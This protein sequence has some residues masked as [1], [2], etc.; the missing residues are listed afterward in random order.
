MLNPKPIPDSILNTKYYSNARVFRDQA[1]N[2]GFDDESNWS[3][4]PRHG[5]YKVNYFSFFFL[6]YKSVKD[7][8]YLQLDLAV[9]WDIVKDE[10][11]GDVVPSAIGGEIWYGMNSGAKFSLDRPGNYLE[12]AI[13]TGL[14]TLKTLHL[15]NRIQYD[16][17]SKLYTVNAL[18]LDEET[19]AVVDEEQ[20]ETEKLFLAAGSVMTSA[21]LVRS[22]AVGDL[23][24]LNQFTGKNW[25]NN[26]DAFGFRFASSSDINPAEGGPASFALFYDDAPSDSTV[27]MNIPVLWATVAGLNNIVATLCMGIPSPDGEFTYDAS[28]DTVTLNWPQVPRPD[29]GSYDAAQEAFALLNESNPDSS[30]A[31]D[32]IASAAGVTGHPQGGFVLGK[33]TDMDCEAYGY[34]GLF[35][36]DGALVNGAAGT[37]NP[38][39]TVAGLAE[40]C[41]DRIIAKHFDFSSGD[42][43]NADTSS[44]GTLQFFALMLVVFVILI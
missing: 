23:P 34:D 39:F 32:P 29:Q 13:D 5:I 18:I 43:S 21:L 19:G 22:K 31:L 14:V 24:D 11:D 38:A 6:L 36:V 4:E 42:S 12:R 9:D 40:R 35:V 28:S 44:A 3:K 25:G 30:G 37:V 16:P 41:M 2:A 7:L 26:G 15:V 1:H 27:L 33:A 20:F 8:L 17:S 10:L